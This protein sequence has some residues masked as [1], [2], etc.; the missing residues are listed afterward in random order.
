MAISLH[1]ASLYFLCSNTGIE[2]Y[3][4]QKL[5]S[6]HF[7]FKSIFCNHV[8]ISQLPVHLNSPLFNFCVAA[9]TDVIRN[10]FLPDLVIAHKT[11]Q[12]E[13]LHGK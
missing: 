5:R 7:Q 8:Y 4:S 13:C 10:R 12:L 2:K 9:A 6:M 11:L 3:F 1:W